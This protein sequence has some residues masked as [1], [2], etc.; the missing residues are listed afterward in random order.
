MRLAQMEGKKLNFKPFFLN[1]WV[2]WLLR[3]HAH[4]TRL[5]NISSSTDVFLETHIQHAIQLKEGKQKP[6]ILN[7]IFHS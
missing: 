4:V 7:C 6:E 2:G 5:L 3:T 1:I